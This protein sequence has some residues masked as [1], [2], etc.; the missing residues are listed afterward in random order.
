M[1]A[2]IVNPWKEDRMVLNVL[3]IYI[4]ILGV[5]MGAYYRAWLPVIVLPLLG[6]SLVTVIAMDQPHV[7]LND[8]GV[9]VR[10][11]VIRRFF[12][13]AEL[14]QVGI[15][16]FETKKPGGIVRKTYKLGLLLPDGLP[17]K[18][19]QRIQYYRNMGRIVYL[20]DTPEIRAFVIARYGLLDFDESADPRGYS[21]LVD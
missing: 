1:A 8:T 13:W 17:K 18:V 21:I 5:A 3:G 11:V 2:E 9:T 7:I 20:P 10:F 15:C 4:G 6:I 19:G 14:R 16:L 12:T